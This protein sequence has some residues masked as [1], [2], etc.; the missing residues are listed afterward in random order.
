MRGS[1]FGMNIALSGLFTAQRNQNTIAHNTANM[2]T[3]GFSRQTTIQSASSP[4]RLYN[5]TGMVGTGVDILAVTRMRDFYLDQ[6]IWYQKTVQ[7]AWAQKA[8]LVDQIQF[9]IQGGADGMGYNAVTN[10][11]YSVLQELS[12][13]ASNMSIRSVAKEQATTMTTYFNNLAE[14]LEK[15]QEDINFD[16]KAK[17]ELIN[18][19]GHR[20]ETL[21]RQIYEV[22]ILGE[23]ANDL[24]DVLN[25]IP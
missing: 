1:F 3:V 24:R 15:L 22:E 2:Q 19:I 4:I 6:K 20:I 7:G 18:S 16:V 25:A 14:N 11:F 23:R 9:R 8:G 17:V 12:K 21:N 10:D 5:K 13:D